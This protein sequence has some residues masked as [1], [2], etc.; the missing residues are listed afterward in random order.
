MESVIRFLAEFEVP[1]Y[2]VLGIVAVVFLRRIVLAVEEKKKAVFG[3]E[4]EAARRNIATAATV[5]ILKRV[6]LP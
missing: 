6:F 5:L 4:R 2:L 1:I 3:L